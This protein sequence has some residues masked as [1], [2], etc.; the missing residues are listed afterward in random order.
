MPLNYFSDNS[1]VNWTF[2]STELIGSVFLYVDYTFPVKELREKLLSI[3]S[4]NTLWDKKTGELLVTNSDE[5]VIE[6]RATFSAK[7][8]SDVWNMRCKIREQLIGFI[9]EKYPASLPKLRRMEVF[10]I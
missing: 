4:D 3:L 9:Q 10:K 2:S 1:F 6:L 5:R 7:D 8:A